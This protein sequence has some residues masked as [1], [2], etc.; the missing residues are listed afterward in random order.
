M[1]SFILADPRSAKILDKVVELDLKMQSICSLETAEK[2][3]SAKIYKENLH[4]SVKILQICMELQDSVQRSFQ[5][6]ADLHRFAKIENLGFPCC[7]QLLSSCFKES[8][9]FCGNFKTA[10]FA[11]FCNEKRLAFVRYTDW[12]N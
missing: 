11:S 8:S 4:T 12:R 2:H 7:R 6:P 1:E 10:S 3:I 5:N 9:N